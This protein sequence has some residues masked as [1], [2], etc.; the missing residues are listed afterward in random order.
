MLKKLATMKTCIL[1]FFSLLMLNGLNAQRDHYCYTPEGKTRLQLSTGHLL[2]KFKENSSPA[3]GQ[4][5]LAQLPGIGASMGTRTTAWRGMSFFEMPEG[6]SEEQ[7]EKWLTWLNENPSVEFAHP[8][9][10]VGNGARQSFTESFVVGLK[11]QADLHLLEAMAKAHQVL[12]AERYPYDP[13]QWLLKATPNS[14]KNALELA[15]LFHESGYFDFAETDFLVVSQLHGKVFPP[16]PGASAPPPP[17]APNDPDYQYQWHHENAGSYCYNSSTTTDADIDSDSAWMVT[18]GR[19]DIKIAIVDNGINIPDSELNLLPGFDATSN[20]PLNSMSSA[21][22]H[23]TNVA[24]VAAAIGNN[25]TCGAGVAY[26]S[27]VI[28]VKVLDVLNPAN[29]LAVCQQSWIARGIDWAWEEA[30]ADV[31]NN[32]YGGGSVSTIIDNAIARAIT[33]GRGGLGA[34]VVFSVGNAELNSIAYP[35]SNSQTIAVGAS[36]PCDERKYEFSCDND[37]SWGSNYGTGLDVLAPGTQIAVC[38]IDNCNQVPPQTTPLLGGTSF[39]SPIAAGIIALILSKNPSLTESQAR[40]YLESTCEKIWNA[41]YQSN[42]PDQPNGTWA[43]ETGYGRVNARIALDSVPSPPATDVGI[44]LITLPTCNFTAT[45]PVTATID[46]Y[47]SNAASNIPVE[48]RL[49]FNNGSFGAWT[50]AGT[51]A[52]II[53]AFSES[54]HSFNI[55]AAATGD[56]TLEVRTQ[57]TGDT[58]SANDGHARDFSNSAISTFPYN[59]DFESNNGD[60]EP[61]LGILWEWGTPTKDWVRTTANGS[62]GW[63]TKLNGNY[64]DSICCAWLTSPCFDFSNMTSDPFLTFQLIYQTQPRLGGAVKDY[65]WVEISTDGGVSWTKLGV[66]GDGTNWYNDAEGWMGVTQEG[67]NGWLPV[68]MQLAGMAGKAEVRLRFQMKSQD[69]REFEGIGIDDLAIFEPPAYDAKILS[70]SSPNSYCNM[71]VEMV[72]V[73]IQN[74]GSANIYTCPVEYRTNGG[75]WTSA[76]TYNG[77]IFPGTAD[78][79][80]FNVDFSQKGSYV[81]EVR[82]Q[83]PSDSDASND[84]ASR[85]FNHYTAI[86]TFPATESFETGAEN[87]II[88]Y[89]S[90]NYSW[91]L[92]TP[93]ATSIGSA[94]DGSNAWMT[95]L[96]GKYNV[97]EASYVQSPCYDFTNLTSPEIMLDIFYDTESSD[98]ANLEYSTDGGNTWNL[99][100]SQGSGNNWYNASVAGL[101]FQDGWEGLNSGWITAQHPLASLAG[102]SEVMFRINFGTGSLT[103]DGKDGFAFD[104]FIARELVTTDAGVTSIDSPGNFGCSFGMNE[105]MTVTVENFGANPVS[106]IPIEYQVT[107]NGIP[108]GWNSAGTLPGPITFGNTATHSFTIDL[109]SPDDK[110]VEVRTQL[111]GDQVSSNDKASKTFYNITLVQNIFPFCEDFEGGQGQWTA[112]GTNSSWALGTP[113]GSKINAASG[114]TKAWATNLSGNYNADETSWLLSP[115]LDLSGMGFGKISFDLWYE[116][117]SSVDGLKLQYTV[118]GGEVWNTEAIE[119]NG[120]NNTNISSFSG[121]DTQE[122]WSGSTGQWV[123]AQA[124]ISP[125]GTSD[126]LYR[127]VFASDSSTSDEGIAIDNLCLYDADSNQIMVF[128]GCKTL[129]VKGVNGNGQFD[130]LDETGTYAGYLNPN[131]NN[132]G[133]VTLDVNDLAT[134]PQ[135]DSNVFYMPR[136]FDF[137]CTGGADCPS[138]GSFPQGNVTVGFY[139]ETFELDDYNASTGSTYTFS[140]LNATHFDGINENCTLDDN[141]T[142]NYAVVQNADIISQSYNNGT[143]FTLEFGIGSFSEFGMHGTPGPLMP[144]SSPLPLELV[145]FSGKKLE[146]ANLLEWQTANEDQ[147]QWHQLERSSD[148]IAWAQIAQL[149]ATGLLGGTQRYQYEDRLPPPSSYYRL[150]SIDFDGQTSL[151]PVIHLARPEGPAG[152]LSVFPMPTTRVANVEFEMRGGMPLKWLLTD[153]TGRGLRSGTATS[154]PGPNLMEINLTG[155]PD[156][157]YFLQLQS[158]NWRSEPVKLVKLSE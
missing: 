7:V 83:L 34:P 134:V 25:N 120:F 11:K 135:A 75:S 3:A 35:A 53:A 19:V 138:S 23:G 143:G 76:G 91:E 13:K 95:N 1:F 153:L 125:L 70:V 55:N 62:K 52:A 50:S 33:K 146:R 108:L 82:T 12:L 121:Y 2:I 44:S 111:T 78:F 124:Y 84:S 24:Y 130:L 92:G 54:T 46:N 151:S 144:P 4:S 20:D 142:G 40:F 30:G 58:G 113:A 131:G 43:P 123:T 10:E 31:L 49:K 148:G 97:A 67:P 88:G 158:A 147:V 66:A 81:L 115:C 69:T 157:M 127:F 8:F 28:P 36:S 126:V 136:Y 71:G 74:L 89:T 118:N 122:G 137:N 129:T 29:N 152:L 39:A 14:G 100:G 94:S 15:N 27:S 6:T 37:P 156:G 114:G 56:Y 72:E 93:S 21:D 80:S 117:Q 38:N 32:S 64:P 139:F 109:S 101:G 132:L 48:Y 96:Q 42:Q 17:A 116:S 26:S 128:N 98:G 104:K 106:N 155:L 103:D 85:N 5:I 112:G 133:T 90:T 154:K 9:F 149:P 105:T 41:N 79:F 141:G 45:T 73:A 47:G 99:V 51:Y 61:N 140:D 22:G 119:V 60:W 107:E 102:N 86:S 65:A 145:Y 18:T 16:N 57:L 87:W 59:E 63:F 110:L 77:N 150:R 68:T